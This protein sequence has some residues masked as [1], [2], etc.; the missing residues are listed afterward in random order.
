MK[1]FTFY[2]LKT[3]CRDFIVFEG[4]SPKKGGYR[5]RWDGVGFL[6]MPSFKIAHKNS[7][8][9]P[10]LTVSLEQRSIQL[11]NLCVQLFVWSSERDVSIFVLTLTILLGNHLHTMHVLCISC[12]QLMY[13]VYLPSMC[14]YILLYFLSYSN[15]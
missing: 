14:N 12:L 15:L 6:S 10:S 9:P 4:K 3:Y 2:C 8:L 11:S 1:N 5:G 13:T 7:S